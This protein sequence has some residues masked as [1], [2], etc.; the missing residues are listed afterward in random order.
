MSNGVMSNRAYKE[1]RLVANDDPVI[2]SQMYNGVLGGTVLWGILVNI[3]MSTVFAD[4]ILDMNYLAVVLIYFI[5]SFVSMLVVYNSSN[6]VISFVGF[7]GLSISMG[8]LL[9]FY[10]SLFDFAS[11][12]LAFVSTGIVV[13]IMIACTVLFPEFFKG[14]GR[15][16]FATLLI[17][18]ATEFILSLIMGIDSTIFDY[19]IV[20]IFCG[21]IGYDWVKAQKY[22]PTLDNAVDSAADI[23]VDIV[24]LFVRILSIIAKRND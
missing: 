3:I 17:A 6:P 14:L 22:T 15:V 24:N 13:G 18:V 1:A 7:T 5:G 20:V 16:L 19:L 4:A 8:L 21:Y 10:V 11:I 9:T 23:Y 12:M 2:T